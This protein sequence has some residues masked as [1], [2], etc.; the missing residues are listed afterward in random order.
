MF[1]TMRIAKKIKQAR[2]GK[3]LTQMNLADAMGIS[4][5]AVSNWERGNSMPDIGKLE[6]LCSILEIDVEELLGIESGEAKTVS[7]VIGGEDGELTIEEVAKVAPILPPERIKQETEKAK[8]SG[9]KKTKLSVVAVMAPYLDDEDIV[10]LLGGF[11]FDFDG[12]EDFS[13]IAM[14]LSDEMIDKIVESA[15]PKDVG[16]I[17]KA[18]E[19]LPK[20]SMQR[21][22]EIT[23]SG[24]LDKLADEAEVFFDDSEI[25]ALAKRCMEENRIDII[26]DMAPFL[27]EATLD[28]VAEFELS[29][30]KTDSLE[31][32]YPYMEPKTLKKLAKRLMEDEDMESLEEIMS[33]M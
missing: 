32:L 24:D 2:I 33:Y 29:K 27:P 17:L 23:E 13:E 22:I 11:D 19:Y 1:D 9:G 5:Q 25:D 30:E 4:Y 3:N 14:Y 10:E 21:L 8:K 15:K 12:V 20:K 16:A 7:K 6:E 31:E 28:A 26:S 18:V